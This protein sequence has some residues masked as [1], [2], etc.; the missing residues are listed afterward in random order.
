MHLEN[1]ADRFFLRR[2]DER[3]G[4]D[5][6][7]VG[8]FRLGNHLHAGLMEM[9]D[10]D[11]A[12]DEILRATEGNET[13]GNHDVLFGAPPPTA[14]PTKNGGRETA[15]TEPGGREETLL[16]LRGELGAGLFAFQ[17]GGAAF[18]FD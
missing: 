14:P 8:F 11:L 12:I 17:V 13:D 10:H 9:T 4:V 15:V 7:N 18:A 5:D 6:H 16:L 2:I 3:A 1:V